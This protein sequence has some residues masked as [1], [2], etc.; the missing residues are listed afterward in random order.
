MPTLNWIGK[1]KII[2][3]HRDVKYRT[4]DYKYHFG[5]KESS[6]MIIHG[7]NLYGLKSLLPRYSGQIDC[8][9]ID[10]P[11]NTGTKE[12]KWLYSD[13][14]D[15]PRIQ[16]WLGE[17]VG[18]EEDD[19]TRHDKWLCMMYPRLRLIRELM[20]DDG[21]LFITLDDNEEVY[22]KNLC[23]EIF[24]Y[25][26]VDMMVWRKSGV[27]RDGKM[28]NTTTFRKDHEFVIVCYKT[29]KVLNKIIEKPNFVNEYPNPDDDPRGPYKAGSISRKESAS[30]PEHKNYYS[31]TAPSGKVFTRQFDIPKDEF[32]RLYSDVMI[33][34]KGKK[35]SRIYWG[36]DDNS[37]PSLK[38][39]VNE[40]RTI[41]PYSLLLEKGTTTEGTKLLETIMETDKYSVM[42]P[43]PVTLVQTLIQ[44]ATKKDSKVLDCFAGTGTTG[45]AVLAQNAKDGGTRKF[46]EIEM[47][48]YAETIVAERTRRVI[49]GY[50]G[51]PG[52][53]GGFDYFELGDYIFNDDGTINKNIPLADIK[54]FIYYSETK[55]ELE[56]SDNCY[57]L[58]EKNATSYYLLMSKEGVITLN[59]KNLCYINKKSE[60]Y[61]IYAEQCTLSDEFLNKHNIIF[62][63]IPNDIKKI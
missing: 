56:E 16:K 42:R 4:I 51:I 27:G 41:T 18:G 62:K 9:F 37:C 49:N 38:I 14:V 55:E 50:D 29:N 24:G 60:N 20:S 32:D 44:L 2:N 21:V 3:H 57:Y 63:K 8:V 54:K 31:V 11:Y 48:D 5:D 15:D 61:V 26:N 28:K 47:M 39:F 30:N 59:S 33:N 10:P 1:E 45:H 22:C 25:S 58:G 35:V 36:K 12:G 23:Y 19:L 40:E 6:N 52:L 43:K 17:V 34:S 13:N 46:I 7:D 53:K